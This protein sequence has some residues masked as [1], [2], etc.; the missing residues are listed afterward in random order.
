MNISVKQFSD[1]CDDFEGEDINDMCFLHT[2][3]YTALHNYHGDDKSK[4]FEDDYY[5]FSV[6]V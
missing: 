4:E 2:I 3:V 1:I 6:K 5:F